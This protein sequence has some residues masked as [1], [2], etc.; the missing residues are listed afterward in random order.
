MTSGLLPFPKFRIPYCRHITLMMAPTDGK[1]CA[2]AKL[3]PADKFRQRLFFHFINTQ[4]GNGMPIK[5]GKYTGR[6]IRLEEEKVEQVESWTL[7]ISPKA[8]YLPTRHPWW[9]TGLPWVL[10]SVLGADGTTRRLPPGAPAKHPVICGQQ[11]RGRMSDKDTKVP[12]EV[13]GEG[14]WARLRNQEED[15][16]WVNAHI[17]SGMG[18]KWKLLLQS[19][20]Q[21][22]E[23]LHGST[24]PLGSWNLLPPK[25][26]SLGPVS[27]KDTLCRNIECRGR[28]CW[29]AYPTPI[30]YFFLITNN[31]LDVVEN[32]NMPNLKKKKK[33]YISFPPLLVRPCDIILDKI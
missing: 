12:W 11:D 26:P 24:V 21:S 1:H 27:L 15:V 31:K 32:D 29:F 9:R 4:H 22:P 6:R 28:R 30:S 7:E 2:S 33:N 17:Y 25:F 8:C 5:W 16:E 20:N 14:R 10:A 18:G 23:G 13:I 19:M 3:P